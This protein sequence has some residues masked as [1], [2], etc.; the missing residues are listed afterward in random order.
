MN[1]WNRHFIPPNTRLINQ[2]SKRLTTNRRFTSDEL[3]TWVEQS[4]DLMLRST[5]SFLIVTY[6]G[7]F[8]SFSHL[9]YCIFPCPFFIPRHLRIVHAGYLFVTDSSCQIFSMF[10]LPAGRS[11]GKRDV[12]KG[13]GN[14]GEIWSCSI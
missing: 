2:I 14:I 12:Q 13:Q 5:V 6:S 3:P 9:S 1:E 7:P 11:D 10:M 4:Q 8:L